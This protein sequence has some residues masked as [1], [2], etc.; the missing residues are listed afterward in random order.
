MEGKGE[1]AHEMLSESIKDKITA[2]QMGGLWNQ[3]T[4]Q[5]GAYTS[6][7]DWT[8]DQIQGQTVY[9]CTLK[10]ANL[11]LRCNTSV[12]S[13]NRID[14]ITFAP[15]PI[16]AKKVEND[17]IQ[18]TS[19]KVVTGKYEM[20]GV[21]CMP[22]GKK[23]VPLVILASGSGPNDADETL[24]PNKIFRDIAQGLG[25]NGI[26]S[27]RFNKRTKTYGAEL[28]SKKAEVTLE[29]E[30]LQD[31]HSAVKQA[32][33]IDGVDANRIYIVGHSLGAST[34]PLMAKRNKDVKG[35]VMLSGNAR[36]LEDVLIDQVNYISSLDSLTNEMKAQIEKLKIQV[37]NVK[38]I[39]KKSFDAKLELPLSL[40]LSYWKYLNEYNQVKTA[41]ALTCPVLIMQGER[42]YQVTMEDFN[43]WKQALGDK[44][45]VSFKSYPGLNHAYFEGKAKAVPAD[46][47]KA[48]NV[49][50]Y[51]I[52]DIAE[53]IN[54][55]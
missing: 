4:K 35:I 2:A 3:L 45:N 17:K 49:P 34:A 55:N 53:W 43:L 24:G 7:S 18:E 19:I 41:K 47:L 20:P 32:M 39:G 9:F 52:T 27:I 30:Y 26:A 23:N 50:A 38:L 15:A 33:K 36:R 48:S 10:F 6:K 46:Y 13:N 14:G 25:D 5:V 37:A 31:I 1:Q 54:K 11:S 16:E 51:V 40:P 22:T 21:L 8:D 29:D 44:K 12:D 28:V 42:D